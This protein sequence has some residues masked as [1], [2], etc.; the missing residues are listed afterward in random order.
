MMKKILS[1]SL[2]F[3]FVFSL[4]GCKD[5]PIVCDAGY[6][7]EGEACI[8]DTTLYTTY[9]DETIIDFEYSNKNFITDGVGEVTLVSCTDGDTAVFS[10]GSNSFPVRFLGIDTPESTYRIDPWGKAA[11]LYTCDKLTNATEIVLEADGDR[12]DGNGRYLAWIWYDGRLLNLELIEQAFSNAKGTYDT[13]YED[14]VY[15]AELRTQITQRRVWGEDDPSYDYSLE[16][17]QITIEELV[18]NPELYEG[19]KIVVTGI[20][21]SRVADHPYIQQGDYGIYIYT[22]YDPAAW[23]FTPGNEVI[24]EGLNLTYYQDKETGT[25][26]LV[27]FYKRNVTVLSQGNIVE[28]RVTTVGDLSVIDLGSYLSISDLEVTEVYVSA[29]TGDY[30]IT[31]EDSLGNTIGLHIQSTVSQTEIDDMFVV[32]SSINVIGPMSRYMGVYQFE[33]SSLD[34]ITKNN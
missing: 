22:G 14:V 2:T 11:S 10:T 9:T 12:M 5:D 8:L 23:S 15:D 13:K 26:Q 25:V 29:N 4:V 30:T 32:E 17:T 3:L 20:V 31:C 34:L 21:S 28:P 6:N 18:T 7:L 27:G 24:V 1:V 19:T 16:G 33:L